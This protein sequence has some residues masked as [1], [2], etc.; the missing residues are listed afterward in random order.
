MEDPRLRSVLVWVARVVLVGLTLGVVGY[1]S[2]MFWYLRQINPPGLADSATVFTVTENDD[3]ETISRRLEQSGVIV[4]DGV[5]RRYV[6]QEGGLTIVPG[7]YTVRGRDHMG[8]ILRVLRTPP[9]ETLTRVTFP[10][11]FTLEQMAA[12]LA[13][14]SNSISASDFVE[15]AGGRADV[16]SAV[17][18]AYQPESV[19]TLEGLLFPDTYFVAGDETATQVIQRMTRLMERVGR[20]EG[21]DDAQTLV[22]YTPYQVLIIAS[23]IEREA[24]VE[25][26]RAKIA[27]VIYNRLFLDMPLQVDATLFY[28][29]DRTR[30]FSELRELDTPYNTYLYKGLPPTPI[31]NPGRASIQAALAPAANPLSGDPLCQDIAQGNPCLLLYYVLADKNGRHDFAVTLAQHEANIQKAIAA[32][33]L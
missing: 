14:N 17:R 24:K 18:S 9:N 27:R 5:F 20:Q 15:K 25:E 7:L 29:Q 32:G 19:T 26:D 28:R 13:E 6:E 12:R 8:N 16:A 33:V 4:H 21:L 10:E 23:I 11:G 22:G 3:L 2:Y 31:A 30:P 1:G